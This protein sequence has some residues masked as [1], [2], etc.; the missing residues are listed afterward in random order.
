[1]TGFARPELLASAEW[2]SDELGRPDLRI[3]D[4]RWRPDGTGQS[5]FDAGH[6]PGAT[7]LDWRAE[8]NEPSSEDDGH[9]LR[10]ASA[11]S[12]GSFMSRAGVGDANT[13][14]LYDDTLGLYAARAWWS[15]RVYGFESARILDGGFPAWI[16]ASRPLS[17]G[18]LPRPEASFQPRLNPRLRLTTTDVRSL[19]GS[20]DAQIIDGRAVP[21]F[22]GHEGNARRLG[23]IPGAVNVPIGALHEAGTQRLLDPNS[24]RAVLNHAAVAKGRRLVCYDG[25][26]VGAA[27]LAFVL[28]ANRE[29]RP[30][31]AYQPARFR[32]P[33]T[34]RT[35]MPFWSTET[36]PSSAS[37]PRIW[38]TRCRVPPTIAAR[39]VW[40]SG[41]VSRTS[42]SAPGAASS[43]S[44]V[45]VSASRPPISRKST[46]SS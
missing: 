6:L 1:V 17:T 2:L 21:E 36:S 34:S 18:V 7:Y 19:L 32:S 40:V 10:L 28:T 39:S 22:K 38:L 35:T 24:I 25:S 26:G 3:V 16:S 8:L 5:V 27:K 30:A 43:A 11:A 13:V 4:V 44:R 37:S 46:S 20:P 9:A 31:R 23:H 29:R 12:V 33:G 15:F 41:R 42:A 14:V 45:N